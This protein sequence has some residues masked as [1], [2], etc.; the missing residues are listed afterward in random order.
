MLQ[1]TSE[2]HLVSKWH[3]AI[4][5]K[6]MGTNFMLWD[7]AQKVTLGIFLIDALSA[8]ELNFE[9]LALAT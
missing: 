6:K 5:L 7:R 8:L 9:T 2:L 3:I 4:I 1:C